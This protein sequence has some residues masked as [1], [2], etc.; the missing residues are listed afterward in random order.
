LSPRCPIFS[1][2][3]IRTQDQRL[4]RPQLLQL[5]YYYMFT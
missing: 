5:S 4:V 3:G 1:Y 2:A